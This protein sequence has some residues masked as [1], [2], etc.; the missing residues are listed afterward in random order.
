MKIRF[1]E[2]TPMELQDK[3]IL[4]GVCGGVAAYKS[5]CLLRGM[6]R[7]GA[8]VRVAMTEA[9]TRFVTPLTFQALSGEA[10]HTGLWDEGVAMPHIELSRGVDAILIAPATADFL[11]RLATGRADDLLS[12]LALAREA[13]LFVA[14]AMNRQMWEHP[15]T[16]RNV[17]TLLADGVRFLGPTFGEQACGEEGEGRMLEPEEIQ[18]AMIAALTPKRLAGKKV[19]RTAGPTF[20]AIDPVRGITNLSSGRMGYALARAAMQ[21]GAEVSIISGPVEIAAPYGVR[22]TRVTSAL[23]MREAVL[24]EATATTLFIA[25]AAVADYRAEETIAQ[26]HKKESGKAP[27]IRLVANPDIL[28][29]VAALPLAPFCV[30]FAAESE[31]LEVFAE[32][33]RKRKKIPLIVGNLVQEGLGGR[34]N[35]VVLFDDQ[36]QHPLPPGDKQVIA[37]QLIEHIADLLEKPHARANRRKNP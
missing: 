5:A 1:H 12:T 16:R 29:E 7:A 3:T 13:P 28:A 27:V 32:E 25:V 34:T 37:R 22:V 24:R 11:A 8:R 2:R 4:L 21:A 15:A 9:A 23:E 30:G 20:E 26:K 14:P 18:E 10:V 36:G 33:K 31:N 17:E 35:R 19:L 6:K